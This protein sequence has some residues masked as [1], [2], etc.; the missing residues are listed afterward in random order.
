[1]HL[2][3]KDTSQISLCIQTSGFPQQAATATVVVGGG[4]AILNGAN[5][6]SCVSPAPREW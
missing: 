3:W 5:Y 2:L 1:M 4:G 6:Y